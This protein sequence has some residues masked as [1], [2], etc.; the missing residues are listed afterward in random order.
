MVVVGS[1][2]SPA[3]MAVLGGGGQMG[4]EACQGAQGARCQPRF[5]DA[6]DAEQRHRQV[7]RSAITPAR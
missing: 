1:G 7:G 6:G 4:R 5:E 2:S 3:A